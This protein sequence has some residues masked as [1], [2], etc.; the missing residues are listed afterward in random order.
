MSRVPLVDLPALHQPLE[1][2]LTATFQRV[3]RSGRYV[4]GPEVLALEAELAADLGVAHAVGV[5]SGTDALTLAL[6]AVG[7]GPGDRV[8]TSAFSFYS[9]AGVIARLGAVPVF[10][11]LDPRTYNLDPREVQVAL[12]KGP[13]RAIL[14][15]HLFGQA[16]DLA[17][18]LELA[19]THQVPIIEDAAQALYATYPMPGSGP[20]PLGTLGA[21]GCFSFFPTKNLGALGDG[22][23]VVTQNDTLAATIRSLRTYGASQK[24]RHERLGANF[25]LDELQAALLRVKRPH[26]HRWNQAR[27]RHALAYHAGLQDLPVG[28]PQ[29]PWGV[30]HHVFHQYVIRVA[31]EEREPLRAHL[32]KAEIDTEVYYPVPLSAQPCLAGLAQLGGLREAHRAAAETLALPV[33]P[34]LGEAELERVIAGVRGFYVGR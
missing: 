34:T 21:V 27:R 10:A 7:V 31:A 25:R 12:Q 19:Q 28:L 5:S 8:I 22:G 9:T 33:H 15:V 13:A 18:L 14:P 6:E 17:P 11:D 29:T 2:E 1:A 4:L 16:A 26:L 24:H 23:L 20:R 3:L 32:A 30:E